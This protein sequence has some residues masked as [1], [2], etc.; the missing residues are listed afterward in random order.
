MGQ[1]NRHQSPGDCRE[2]MVICY[3]GSGECSNINIELYF[4]CADWCVTE[5]VT[6]AKNWFS[7]C[8]GSD[9]MY[10][11]IL[12]YL[13]YLKKLAFIS[14]SFISLFSFLYEKNRRETFV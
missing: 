13:N 1:I 10:S 12:S 3:I 11:Y 9:V 8:P 2:L 14:S 5:P 4:V 7:N 6:A